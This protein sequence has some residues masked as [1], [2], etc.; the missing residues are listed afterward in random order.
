MFKIS[1]LQVKNYFRTIF[2]YFIDQL[3]KDLH[4]IKTMDVF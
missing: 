2:K 4:I 1:D 3:P